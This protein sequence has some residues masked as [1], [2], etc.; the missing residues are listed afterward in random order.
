MPSTLTNRAGFRAVFGA[1]LAVVPL[2]IALGRGTADISEPAYAMFHIAESYS[3][4]RGFPYVDVAGQ[5]QVTSPLFVVWLAAMAW[6]GLPLP[7][8]ALLS[9]AAAWSLAALAVRDLGRRMGFPFGGALAALLI[10]CSPA[11]ATPNVLATHVPWVVCL[12]WW[13]I[14]ATRTDTPRIQTAL[15]CS[16]LATEADAVTVGLAVFLLLWRWERSGRKPWW[17]ALSLGVLLIAWGLVAH[18]GL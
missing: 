4:G 1:V 17:T 15:L 2:V 8:I 18:S 3:T 16:L 9:G 14:W 10:A 6:V 11:S 5:P 12:A 7:W 13:A